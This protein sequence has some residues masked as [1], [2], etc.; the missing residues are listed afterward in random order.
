MWQPRHVG[1]AGAIAI[2]YVDEGLGDGVQPTFA[3]RVGVAR[4]G[5]KHAGDEAS[6]GEGS[7]AGCWSGDR[8]RQ[9]ER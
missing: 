7:H 8:W 9:G 3:E 4:A 6:L 2:V 1:S 5:T